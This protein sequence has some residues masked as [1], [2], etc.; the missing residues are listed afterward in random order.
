MEKKGK[1]SD[2]SKVTRYL[3]NGELVMKMGP[4]LSKKDG[5][6]MVEADRIFK[7]DT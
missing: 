2:I 5:K 3:L 4:K 6:T 7:R 1:P